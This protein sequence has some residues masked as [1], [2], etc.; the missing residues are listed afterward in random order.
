VTGLATTPGGNQHAFL[1]DGTMHD[2]G[3]LGGTYSEGNGINDSGQVTG[4]SRI[5]GDVAIHAF[6]YDG[7]M[8]DLGTLGGTGSNG[9][10]INASGQVTGFA[11]WLGSPHAFVYDAANGMR[12]LNSLIPPSSGWILQYGW[13]I[14]D[15]GQITGRGLI[16]GKT[17]AFL[18]TPVP[19][20]GSEVL[21]IMACG[22]FWVLSKRFK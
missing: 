13:A 20:P 17:H 3:T 9:S 6:L 18:L 14:N 19:E 5:T 21:A 1:Y 15:L 22:L 8:H 4:Y 7:T 10:D 12:D 11:D 16:G 2:L